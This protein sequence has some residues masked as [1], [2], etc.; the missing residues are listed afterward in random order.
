MIGQTIAVFTS[1]EEKTVNDRL[2]P[3]QIAWHNFV[4][5]HGGISEIWHETKNGEVE[6][7]KNAITEKIK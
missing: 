2:K 7:T 1:I 6:V 5:E 3:G 4:I